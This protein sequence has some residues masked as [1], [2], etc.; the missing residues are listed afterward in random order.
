MTTR[1]WSRAVSAQG[2]VKATAG[3]INV[4]V[5]L[6]GQTARAM[7]AAQARVEKEAA[8]RAALARGQLGLDWYC[9]RDQLGDFGIQY[10]S[11][12]EYRRETR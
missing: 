10:V 1:P 8:N 4:P 2:T 3:A 9:L 11:F 12:A 7:A 5:V 6:G